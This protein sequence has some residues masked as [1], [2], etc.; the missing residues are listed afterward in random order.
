MAA[1]PVHSEGYRPI[2]LPRQN[3]PPLESHIPGHS[4]HCIIRGEGSEA[5][6][7]LR[8][9]RCLA[10]EHTGG[11][12]LLPEAYCR[13]SSLLKRQGPWLMPPHL[14]A[15]QSLLSPALAPRKGQQRTFWKSQI[16]TPLSFQSQGLASSTQ[17]A[18]HRPPPSPPCPKDGF[19]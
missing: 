5:R 8:V 9:H 4:V 16:G 13:S 1:L 11:R 17:L 6:I 14:N 18:S 19:F 15:V 7:C 10:G 2:A 3:H 12:Q